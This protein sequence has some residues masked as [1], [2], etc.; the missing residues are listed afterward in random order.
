MMDKVMILYGWGGSLHPHWQ[1]WLARELVSKHHMVWFPKLPHRYSPKRHQWIEKTKRYLEVFRPETVICHSLGSILWL[2]LCHEGSITPIKR[3]LMVTPPHIH[4]DIPDIASF[5]PAPIPKTL[6]AEESLL[7]TSTN[8]P[9]MNTEQA[10]AMQKALAIPMKM[11]ENV[12]HINEKSGFGPWPFVY[13]WVTKTPWKG[14]DG[15]EL[16]DFTEN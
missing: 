5:F 14:H 1:D 9:Y 12:G 3:L 10:L 4:C 7:V 11:L 16:D 8:D 15:K 2:H 13:E 6:K